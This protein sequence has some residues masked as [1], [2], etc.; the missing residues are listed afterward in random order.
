VENPSDSNE[1]DYA[2]VWLQKLMTIFPLF[3]NGF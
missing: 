1:L 2:Y 3:S